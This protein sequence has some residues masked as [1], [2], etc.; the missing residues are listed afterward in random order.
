MAK[1][2]TGSQEV[3]IPVE[4]PTITID[5]IDD[6]PVANRKILVSRNT[7]LPVVDPDTSAFLISRSI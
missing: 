6:P 5:V 7:G 1:R 2:Y 3:I 4:F